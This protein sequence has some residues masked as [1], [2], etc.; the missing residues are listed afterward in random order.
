MVT[1]PDMRIE[2][3]DHD[4]VIGVN[5]QVKFNCKGQTRTEAETFDI[6][7][8]AIEC[9]TYLD[10]TM[11]E[12]A[13]NSGQELKIRNPSALYIVVAE[14]LKLT[15]DVN[16]HKYKVDQIYILR[17]Q[18]NTDREYRFLPSYKKNQI[19]EDVVINLFELVRD[20][21]TTDWKKSIQFGLERGWLK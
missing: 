7:A 4:F 18:K 20:H 13:S 1:I 3:K 11:L 2:K 5:I 21:L 10:K 15:E 12:G 17:K 14:W 9:K 19:A 16:L 6:P 8:V